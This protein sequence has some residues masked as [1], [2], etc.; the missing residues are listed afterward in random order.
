KER[1][2]QMVEQSIGLVTALVPTLGYEI[3]SDVAKKALET[4]GSIY[5]IVLEEGHLSKEDL[6]RILSP[7]AMLK[8][9]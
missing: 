1:C 6:D 5:Q 7:E 3:C 9:F 8:P 4:G 2:R